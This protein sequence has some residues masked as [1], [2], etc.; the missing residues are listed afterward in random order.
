VY[1]ET[2][3]LACNVYNDGSKGSCAR[4][5]L[6]V[7]LC[8]ASESR[9]R[10]ILRPPPIKMAPSQALLLCKS[11]I[12]VGS[13]MPCRPWPCLPSPGSTLLHLIPLLEA[14][15]RWVVHC[16]WKTS[17]LPSRNRIFLHGTIALAVHTPL[18]STEKAPC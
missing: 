10:V 12:I 13:R 15:S 3:L 1:R 8:R 14:T 17:A 4:G 2:L 11:H 18:C 5:R 16:W 9:T 6:I 7:A